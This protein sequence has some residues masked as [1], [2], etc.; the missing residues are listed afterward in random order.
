MKKEVA[1]HTKELAQ[2]NS[3]LEKMNSE[4]QS[5]AL[6]SAMTSQ[7]PLRKIQMFAGVLLERE[8]ENLSDK[9]KNKFE[10]IQSAANRMQTLINDLVAY[11]RTETEERVFE[12]TSLK[13][14]FTDAKNDLREEIRNKNATIELT[15]NCKVEVI[16]F[17]FR[18]LLYNIMSNSLKYSKENTPPII[19]IKG[20]IVNSSEIDDDRL[21][22]NRN[23]VHISLSDNGIGFD[24]NFSEKILKSFKDFI[25]AKT[26]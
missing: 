23:Y 24:N 12:T 18:Q 22:K 9:G 19:K 21:T 4:L 3:E 10:R 25:R 17:Q 14:L 8:F 1:L 26:M 20:E 16:P 5:F 13:E 15:S 7:E 2:N 11:S 6:S